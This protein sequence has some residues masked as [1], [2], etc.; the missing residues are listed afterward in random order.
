MRIFYLVCCLV[1]LSVPAS[2]NHIGIYA[3]QT[4][5]AC[6]VTPVPVITTL[7]VVALQSTGTD[8]AAFKVNA[9]IP[10]GITPI[11]ASPINFICVTDC[12]PYEGAGA[13]RT[14]SADAW[15][16]YSLTFLTTGPV[17]L[18]TCNHLTVT[19]YP[20]QSTPALQDCADNIMPA[21][22]GSFSFV[23]GPGQC[24]DCALATEPTTWGS[25]KAL[26]R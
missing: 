4:G 24:S 19:A 9:A 20:G 11:G 8:G 16:M 7:Y 21:T 12:N 13:I 2:A 23:S 1:L 5:G 6:S 22:G 14:C 18:S 26:Y 25:V 10:A 15:P 17:N 3:E